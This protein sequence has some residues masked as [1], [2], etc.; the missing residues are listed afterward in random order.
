MLHH[1]G[2]A[3]TFHLN[4]IFH[5]H[6]LWAPP[7]MMPPCSCHPGQERELQPV[8]LPDPALL[9]PGGWEWHVKPKKDSGPPDPHCPVGRTSLPCPSPVA[10]PQGL[11]LQL[12]G[13]PLT[14]CSPQDLPVSGR[15]PAPLKPHRHL[16]VAQ[17][18][19]DLPHFR[20]FASLFTVPAKCFLLWSHSWSSHLPR[21]L[22]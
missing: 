8:L 15:S 2:S 19:Q 9:R 1:P 14:Y 16:P 13:N 4:S 20:D 6:F 3:S 21:G 10:S 5:Q 18:C 11:W 12:E 22:P 7:G 17:T